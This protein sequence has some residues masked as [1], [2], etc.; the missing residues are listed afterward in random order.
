[1]RSAGLALLR[2]RPRD[3]DEKRWKFHW[4]GFAFGR[5]GKLTKFRVL[6]RESGE[7]TRRAAADEMI[8][9]FAA[10]DIRQTTQCDR[11]GVRVLTW[12]LRRGR[13]RCA[14]FQKERFQKRRIWAPAPACQAALRISR[15][16]AVTAEMPIAGGHESVGRTRRSPFG[17]A[18]GRRFCVMCRGLHCWR[19][20]SH[21]AAKESGS[22]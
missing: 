19:R 9:A 17:P 10:T 3:R 21:R 15:R 4:G 6:M 8:G 20:T 16:G 22:A 13:R 5:F 12:F 11:E 7:V 14:S 2:S 18:V 1:M